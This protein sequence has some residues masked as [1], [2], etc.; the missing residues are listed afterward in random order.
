MLRKAWSFPFRHLPLCLP[1]AMIAMAGAAAGEHRPSARP[2]TLPIPAQVANGSTV[3]LRC[4]A[5]YLG[6]LELNGKANITVKTVGN[7]GKATISPGRP[8]PHWT[9]YQGNIYSAPVNFIPVQVA[10]DGNPV[11][12][13]HWPRLPQTWASSAGKLAGKDLAGATL[14]YL[15]SRSVIKSERLTSNSIPTDKPFYVEGK[16]WMLDGPGAW[17]LHQGRL[18]LWTPDG[19]S[20][21]GRV[22]AAP[23][24]N[25]INADQSSGITID[26]VRIFLASHG[27]SANTATRLKVLNSDIVNSFQ[28]GI[29]AS[30]SNGLVVDHT[31]VSNARRN[32]IDGWYSITGA[33]VTNS[34]VSNTGMTGMP[35]PTDAGIFFGDGADNR[36]DHVRV[37][38]S[39]YH[40]ISVLHNRNTSVTNSAVDVACV[41]LTDCGGIYTGARDKQPLRLRIE[42]NT[43]TNVQGPEGYGIY[44]DDSA[45]GVTVSR[46]VLS[47]NTKGMVVHDGFDNRITHNTFSGSA[48][49][50]LAFAQDTGTIR[51]NEVT[52]NTFLSAHGEQT[53]NLEG[54]GNLASFARFDFNTYHSADADTFARTWDGSSPGV[55]AGYGAWRRAMR[56]DANSVMKRGAAG[57]EPSTRPAD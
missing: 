10:V 17:A 44:L 36:I 32:G 34:T 3:K 21:D 13:A 54:G 49:T 50:H 56:Q 23:E 1:L 38:N 14:V 40:G 52:H 12:A 7:C 47:N 55:S 42:G 9:K 20:P 26:G 5:T 11:A 57:R 27:I 2:A 51:G 4:G 29:W 33:T 41:R 15:D 18:Y 35:S 39:A 30:G 31:S 43:V 37:I 24:S 6:T 16:L 22:W 46:N 25:G 19:K 48:I 53:F 8:I 45:N 28:D